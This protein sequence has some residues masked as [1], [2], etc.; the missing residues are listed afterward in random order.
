M[1]TYPRHYRN[2]VLFAGAAAAASL[3]GCA[4][5][6]VQNPAGRQVV[7]LQATEH[8]A[9]GGTGIESQDI[10]AVT[11][12]MARSILSAPVIAQALTPPYVVV[13]RVA[14]ETR[15][16]IQSDIFTDRIRAQL[17][18]FA[19]NKVNFVA[20]DQ[21]TAAALE[22]ERA[23]KQAGQVTASSD[24]NV[25][26]ARGA[27]FFLTGKISSHT[28]GTSQGISDYVYFD[29]QLVDARTNVTKWEDTYE[30]KKEGLEDA[31]YR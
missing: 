10:V 29:F 8:G 3:A 14:N 24:P 13:N 9:V 12:K 18:K 15:F 19:D 1:R 11:D 31:A 16:P 30:M 21:A 17:V 25:V 23:L 6:A 20:R 4:D 5:Y 2:Y 27:D 28:T 7:E 22:H 26:E